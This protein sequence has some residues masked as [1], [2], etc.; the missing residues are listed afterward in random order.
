MFFIDFTK[1]LIYRVCDEVFTF[2]VDLYERLFIYVGHALLEDNQ[3]CILS[4]LNKEYISLPQYNNTISNK[5]S[6]KIIIFQK[7]VAM[8]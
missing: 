3:Q 7:N 5:F 4:T 8:K 1:F 2:C 6:R